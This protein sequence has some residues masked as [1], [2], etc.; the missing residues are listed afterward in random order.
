MMAR[1]AAQAMRAR[2]R[3]GGNEISPSKI[4]RR[5]AGNRNRLSSRLASYVLVCHMSSSPFRKLRNVWL[6][7]RLS[8][9]PEYC[10]VLYRM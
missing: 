9:E 8:P 7:S 4:D 10:T 3:R 6:G 5:R 1:R 2:G